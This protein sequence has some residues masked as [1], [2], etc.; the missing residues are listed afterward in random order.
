MLGN[1]GNLHFADQNTV[2]I[3][4][5]FPSDG[6]PVIVTNTSAISFNGGQLPYGVAGPTGREVEIDRSTY[7]VNWFSIMTNLISGGQRL[8]SNQR[9]FSSN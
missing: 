6:A 3:Q 7:L 2:I 1:A 8:F 9:T 5:G 4:R